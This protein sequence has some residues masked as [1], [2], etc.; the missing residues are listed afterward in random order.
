MR[1]GMRLGCDWDNFGV[2]LD[3]VCVWDA[4]GDASGINFGSILGSMLCQ[5]CGQ[6]GVNFGVNLGSIFISFWHQ[7]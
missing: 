5:C 6:S 2:I 1:L 3:Q 4:I 7:F